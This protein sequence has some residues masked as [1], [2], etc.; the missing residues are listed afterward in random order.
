MIIN[1]Y[2][3]SLTII[4]SLKA[5]VCNSPFRYPS[6]GW[7]NRVTLGW[8]YL[9]LNGRQSVFVE[10]VWYLQFCLVRLVKEK[11]HSTSTQEYICL[12]KSGIHIN[13]HNCKNKLK[14]K[15][16]YFALVL[17]KSINWTFRSHCVVIKTWKESAII[18]QESSIIMKLLLLKQDLTIQQSH[19]GCFTLSQQLLKPDKHLLKKPEIFM[20]ALE[21]VNINI[22]QYECHGACSER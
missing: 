11:L 14:L 9:L 13:K 5:Q 7:N 19:G 3:A 22:W 8:S 10:P 20:S 2:N 18:S 4:Y 1:Q 12:R 16:F 17:W 15:I 6:I 21:T